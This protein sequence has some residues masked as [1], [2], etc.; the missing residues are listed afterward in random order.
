MPTV[1]NTQIAP[2]TFVDES[3]L[4]R[5][6]G[7]SVP[8]LRKDR[9]NERKIPFIRIGKLVRYDLNRVLAVLRLN[10]IGGP[11]QTPARETAKRGAT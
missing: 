7:V 9:Q 6:I 2:P 1:T 11:P 10:E 5:A 8:T 3:H 4:A